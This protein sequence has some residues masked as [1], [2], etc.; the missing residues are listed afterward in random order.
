MLEDLPPFPR[1]FAY[2]MLAGSFIIIGLL[3]LLVPLFMLLITAFFWEMWAGGS[4]WLRAP[5]GMTTVIAVSLTLTCVWV[6]IVSWHFSPKR[7]KKE[8]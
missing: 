3:H 5:E 8:C 1:V 7:S 2:M 6:R 4:E